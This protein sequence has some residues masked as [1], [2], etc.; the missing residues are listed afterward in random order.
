MPGTFSLPTRV[1]DRDM[2]HGTYIDA[3]AVMHA[4]IALLAVLFEVCGMENDP[5]VPFPA[6]VQ[7]AGSF[8]F[9]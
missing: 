9:T 8:S 2:L 4:E 6:H 7:P 3:H 5:T 1:S